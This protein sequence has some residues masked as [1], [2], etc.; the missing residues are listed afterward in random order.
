MGFFDGIGDFLGGIAPAA[1]G[2]ATSLIPGVGPALA[3]VA[4]G[5]TSSLIGGGSSGGGSQQGMAG[6][7]FDVGQ[8]QSELLD[9]LSKIAI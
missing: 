5:L 8:Q 7:G 2:A 3:P 4:A 6:G 1:A 9:K